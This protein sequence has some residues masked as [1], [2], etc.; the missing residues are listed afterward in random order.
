MREHVLLFISALVPDKIERGHAVVIAGDS[1]TV[2]DARARAQACQRLDD[3]RKAASEV[4]TRT[5]IESHLRAVLAGND[6]EAVMLDLM[7]PL[8]AGR[9]LVG[10]GW[11]ARRDEPCRQGT[12]QHVN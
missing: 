9:Q 2:D 3:Q 7:Q 11:K 4:I 6:A 1:F 8:A 5:A 12:L 10:S